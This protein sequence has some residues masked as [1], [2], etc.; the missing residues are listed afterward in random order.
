MDNIQRERLADLIRLLRGQESLRSFSR[1]LGVSY[2]TVSSWE[3]CDAVP[4]YKYLERIADLRG[5]NIYELLSY[6]RDEPIPLQ[7]RNPEDLLKI[8][9]GFSKY[10]RINVAREL[11]V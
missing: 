7:V 9:S 4:E 2:V 6:L 8:A 5:W 11:L 10:D 1:R 3:H